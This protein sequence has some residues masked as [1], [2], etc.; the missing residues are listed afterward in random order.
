M[1]G[2]QGS[3][4]KL[5]VIFGFRD[6]SVDRVQRCLDSLQKQME[7]GVEVLFIDYGSSQKVRKPVEDLLKKYSFA[8]YFYSDS[9]GWPWSRSKALNIGIRRAQGE[10]VCTNDI[11]MVFPSDWIK[12]VLSLNL[13]KGNTYYFPTY[14]LPKGFSDWSALSSYQKEVYEQHKGIAIYHKDTLHEIGAYD[15]SYV[16]WGQEDEDLF[17]RLEANGN[18]T[19]WLNREYVIYHQWHPLSSVSLPNYLPSCFWGEVQDRMWRQKDVILRNDN[20]WGAVLTP[21]NRRIEDYINDYSKHSKYEEFDLQPSFHSSLMRA[22]D[23]FHLSESGTLL[24]FKN[25]EY[26]RG[27]SNL[28]KVL[29]KLSWYLEKLFNLRSGIHMAPNLVHNYLYKLIE[30]NSDL[31]EDYYLNACGGKYSLILKK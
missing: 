30:N 4:T 24:V 10:F 9:Q 29:Q 18:K 19:H 26:P 28:G 17:Y 1:I 3:D 12:R 25:A 2:G 14:F 27:A 8:R 15:E 11:D 16:F 23:L 6:R 20:S 5:S 7:S 13:N 31:I 21:E 22:V